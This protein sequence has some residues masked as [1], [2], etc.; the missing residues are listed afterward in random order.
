MLTVAGLKV[1]LRKGESQTVTAAGS[2]SRLREERRVVDPDDRQ[3]TPLSG[4]RSVM[5]AQEALFFCQK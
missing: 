1:F 5:R 4:Q 3:A 2:I